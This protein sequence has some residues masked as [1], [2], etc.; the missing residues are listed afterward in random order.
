[1]HTQ[2]PSTYR[3]S[4]LSFV[5]TVEIRFVV[6]AFRLTTHWSRC[7][8]TDSSFCCRCV[9]VINYCTAALWLRQAAA[10][11]VSCYLRRSVTRSD[12]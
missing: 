10:R 11:L 3:R 1:M 12:H 7:V 6:S 2:Y 8:A 4:L 9:C 5:E